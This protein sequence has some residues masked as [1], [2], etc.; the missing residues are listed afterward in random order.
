LSISRDKTYLGQFF[1]IYHVGLSQC[2]N[3][4]IY[5]GWNAINMVKLECILLLYIELYPTPPMLRW[6]K[7]HRCF[8]H[9]FLGKNIGM[10]RLHAGWIAC[11]L[12]PWPGSRRWWRLDNS[13]I[14]GES[15]QGGLHD[16][17]VLPPN[18][19][20]FISWNIPY[21]WMMTGGSHISGTPNMC[22][23][24]SIYPSIHPSIHLSIL[25][26]VTNQLVSWLIF[27]RLWSLSIQ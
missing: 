18:A 15:S 13:P 17:M 12:I 25:T 26:R 21:K 2:Q 22:I 5:L 8:N 20:W 23:Y 11:L 1:M 6:L 19:G 4:A 7:P 9:I 10:F 24:L 3:P 27:Q 14:H 16:V